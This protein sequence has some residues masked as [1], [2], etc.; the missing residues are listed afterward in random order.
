MKSSTQTGYLTIVDGM[1]AGTGSF[2]E[3]YPK[4]YLAKIPNQIS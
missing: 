1:I 4:L 2:P 3:A